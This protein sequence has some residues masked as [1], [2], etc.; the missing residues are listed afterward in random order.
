MIRFLVVSL[1]GASAFAQVTTTS[2]LHQM[3]DLKSTPYFRNYSSHQFS[4]YDRTGGN[5]DWDNF[6]RWEGTDAVLAEMDGPGAVT[7]IWSADSDS[8]GN[9]RIYL[10][11]N[12]NPIINT[13]FP[14]YFNGNIFGVSDPVSRVVDGSSVSFSSMPIPFAHHCKIVLENPANLYYHVDW[15]QFPPGTDVR[16]FTYPLNG[17]EQRALE[18][19]ASVWNN[20][21]RGPLSGI[22]STQVNAGRNSE[23]ARIDGPGQ[24]NA[25][26]L[27]VD[28]SSLRNLVLRVYFDGHGQPDIEAPLADLFGNPFTGHAA[29]SLFTRTEGEFSVFSLPMPFGNQMLVTLENG[30]KSS[31]IVDVMADFEAGVFDP[32]AEGYLHAQFYNEYTRKNRVHPLVNIRGQR[33]HFVGMVESW[34]DPKSGYGF[35]EGDEQIRVDNEAWIPSQTKGTVIGP[36]NGTGTEDYYNSGYYFF[37]GLLERPTYGVV[38][39]ED[40][41]RL[42]AYR[43]HVLEAPTFQ[44]SIDVQMEHGATNNN[45]GTY[46]SS[47]AFWYA[48]GLSPRQFPITSA[49]KLKW[50]KKCDVLCKIK[51]GYYWDLLKHKLKP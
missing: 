24:V 47:L 45:P 19:V 5:R 49:A 31:V 35:L 16:T 33:G 46:M 28:S 10:D 32:N 39:K 34:V 27:R 42:A 3:A 38:V 7:R 13:K 40:A 41:G 20:P 25:L 18:E 36:W 51:S 37:G 48:S 6:V 26:A 9:V 4:S 12:P 14:N 15:I 21:P 30:T 22:A 11:N 29:Q 44:S 2:L 8:A 43:W 50:P 17:E 1:L 23:V